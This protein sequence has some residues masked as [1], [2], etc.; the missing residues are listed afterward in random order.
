ME[1]N[2]KIIV[3]M[4]LDA[5]SRFSDWKGQHWDNQEP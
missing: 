4:Y 2:N 3:V 1:R 5:H